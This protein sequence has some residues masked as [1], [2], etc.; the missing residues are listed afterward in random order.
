LVAFKDVSLMQASLYIIITGMGKSTMG[1]KIFQFMA[2]HQPNVG[3]I[4]LP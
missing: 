3:I 4:L 1:N 2:I